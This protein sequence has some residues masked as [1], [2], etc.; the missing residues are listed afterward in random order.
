MKIMA[1][2]RPGVLLERMENSRFALAVEAWQDAHPVA[3]ERISK[4]LHII[5]WGV[6]VL[7]WLFSALVAVI[8]VRQLMHGVPFMWDDAFLAGL[9]A[10]VTALS[11]H[12]LRNW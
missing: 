8:L 5:F 12:M 3:A 2:I 7:S 1:N 6:S 11:I 10:V 4:G 9:A